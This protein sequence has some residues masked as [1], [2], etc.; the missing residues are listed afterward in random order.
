MKILELTDSLN[1]HRESVLIP[2]VA[3]DEGSVTI[4]P[5][6]RLRIVVP[7]NKPFDEWLLELKTQ[8]KNMNLS[9]VQN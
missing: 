5:N 8:L 4:L 7:K 6:Q 1:L 2:L 9:T 3:G